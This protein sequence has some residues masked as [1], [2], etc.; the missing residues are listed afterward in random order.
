MAVRRYTIFILVLKD[1]SRVRDANDRNLLLKRDTKPFQFRS[2]KHVLLHN[3]CK[4]DIITCEENVIFTG[5]H[6]VF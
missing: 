6:K 2:E 4:I 1:I 3:R 5:E